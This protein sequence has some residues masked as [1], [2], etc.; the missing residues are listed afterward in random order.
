MYKVLTQKKWNNRTRDIAKREWKNESWGGDTMFVCMY[1]HMPA[2][3]HRLR[4]R[5]LFFTLKYVRY[6]NGPF[7]SNIPDHRN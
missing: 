5:D 6:V 3:K 7:S 2:Y 1:E 4:Q